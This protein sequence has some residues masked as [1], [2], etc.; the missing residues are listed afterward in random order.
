MAQ[1]CTVALEAI[2]KPMEELSD[3]G[4]KMYI[5]GDEELAM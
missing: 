1:S 4:P 3:L 2:H 5:S